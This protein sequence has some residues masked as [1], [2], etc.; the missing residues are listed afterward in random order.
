V[1]TTVPLRL[2]LG[3]N[4]FPGKDNAGVKQSLMGIQAA[5]DIFIETGVQHLSI[6]TGVSINKWNEK[7][8]PEPAG[9]SASVKGIKFGARFGF[10]YQVNQNWSVNTMLQVV[11]L[12]VNANSTK[13]YN[14]SWVQIGA[15]Y[16]F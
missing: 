7:I 2:S 5:G 6:L 1:G 12:G 3:I 13:G 10:E 15:K 8:S 16:H 11:E 4:D 14:P 9:Y